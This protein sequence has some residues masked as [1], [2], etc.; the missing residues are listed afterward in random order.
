M[1]DAWYRDGLWAFECT[2]CDRLR[3]GTRGLRL[4]R[5]SMEIRRLAVHLK[6]TIDSFGRTYLRQVEDRISLVEKAGN[7]CVF[8]DAKAGCTA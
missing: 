6:L 4:G 5:V 8:W 3:A 2:R 7:A 1:D